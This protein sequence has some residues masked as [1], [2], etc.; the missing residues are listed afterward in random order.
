MKTLYTISIALLS[1]FFTLTAANAQFKKEDV[2]KLEGTWEFVKP[3]NP[4]DGTPFFTTLRTFDKE[5]NYEEIFASASGAYVQ[6]RAR[7]EL[8]DNSALPGP[9]TYTV[10]EVNKFALN[11]ARLG[12]TFNFRCG[13]VVNNGHTLLITEGGKKVVDGVET[14]DWREIWRKV[15]EPIKKQ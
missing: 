3:Q 12:K 8:G 10:S 15:K 11:E 2:G 7:F 14:A 9:F 13:I 1:L 6:S 5:G 4:P